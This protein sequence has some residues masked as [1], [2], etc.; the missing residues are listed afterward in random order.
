MLRAGSPEE[1]VQHLRTA[2]ARTADVFAE[3]GAELNT[4]PGKSA[5][6]LALRGPGKVAVLEAVWIDGE[7][8]WSARG[9]RG[10]HSYCRSPIGTI[11]W[12]A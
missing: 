5:G 9:R 1:C 10:R 11:T 7:G 4:D 6:L 8:S 12:G 3:W 2:A